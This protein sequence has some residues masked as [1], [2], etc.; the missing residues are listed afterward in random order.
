MALEVGTVQGGQIAALNSS[1]EGERGDV[2]TTGLGF[3]PSPWRYD[4]SDWIG[5]LRIG[6][7]SSAGVRETCM[8]DRAV[9]D[10]I[11]FGHVCGPFVLT[12]F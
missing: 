10:A 9:Y 7:V 3:P 2:M 11:K 4:R 12:F 5:S 1:K 8:I 6:S